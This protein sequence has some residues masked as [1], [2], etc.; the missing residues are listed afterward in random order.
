M[1]KR[2]HIES[3]VYIGESEKRRASDDF[4][5]SLYLSLR[6][7]D[8]TSMHPSVG[9]SNSKDIPPGS[10]HVGMTGMNMILF[11]STHKNIYMFI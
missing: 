4:V 2:W 3:C 1:T 10:V 11:A 7:F 9:Q 5:V 8:D 6:W